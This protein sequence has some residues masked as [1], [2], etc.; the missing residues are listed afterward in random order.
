MVQIQASD[1]TWRNTTFNK[2]IAGTIS[3]IFFTNGNVSM[4]GCAVTYCLSNYYGG[5]VEFSQ[6]VGT[7]RNTLFKNITNTNIPQGGAGDGGAVYIQQNSKL[8]FDTCSFEDNWSGHSGSAAFITASTVSIKSS[9]FLRN[10]SGYSG[11]G[12]FIT[13]STCIHCCEFRLGG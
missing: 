11:G 4:D 12:V 7:V 9:R 6:M 3:P 13:W 10:Y 2:L 1:T 8:V 5:G